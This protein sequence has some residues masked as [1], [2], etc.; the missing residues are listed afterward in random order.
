M[1]NVT[2]DETTSLLPFPSG[3]PTPKPHHNLAGLSAAKFRLVC[4]SLW[5]AGF[6]VA[7]DSTI[8]ATLLYVIFNTYR[9]DLIPRPD[10]TLDLISTLRIKQHG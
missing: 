4:L 8:V 3:S 10:Q 5:S 7:L 6:L 9:V 1:S 2:A